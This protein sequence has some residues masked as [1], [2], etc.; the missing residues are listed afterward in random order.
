MCCAS[1]V[2]VSKNVRDFSNR[3][4][5]EP[6]MI[7]QKQAGTGKVPVIVGRAGAWHTGA[8]RRVLAADAWVAYW[9]STTRSYPWVGFPDGLSL[10]GCTGAGEIYLERK[11]HPLWSAQ[12]FA[13][14]GEEP[15]LVYGPPSQGWW[16]SAMAM[17]W[18]KKKRHSTLHAA[19]IPVSFAAAIPRKFRLR[20]LL[21]DIKYSLFFVRAHLLLLA[22]SVRIS[23]RAA[24]PMLVYIFFRLCVGIGVAM[25]LVYNLLWCHTAIQRGSNMGHRLI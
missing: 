18:R 25:C 15:S 7:R 5:T 14:Q 9:S 16:S 12:L 21:Y 11:E 10:Q 23:P 2:S 22:V 4:V 1:L 8:D 19:C 6:T 3:G 17:F 24:L 20:E 13:R